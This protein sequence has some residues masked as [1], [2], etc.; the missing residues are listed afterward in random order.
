MNLFTLLLSIILLTGKGEF[1]VSESRKNQ[2]VTAGELREWISFLASDEM[3]GRRNGSVES[4][5]AAAWISGK[6]SEFGVGFVNDKKDFFQ[7]YTF[8]GRGGNV[9]ERNVIGMIKGTNPALKDQILVITAHFDHI[10]IRKGMKPDSV[11]NGADDNASGI[12]ALLGVAKYIGRS[13]VKPGRTVLFAAVSGEESGMRGSRYFVSNCPFQ[14]TNIVADINFEMIGHSELLG[15][16]RYYM[17]G[18][19]N[20]NLDDLIK[21]YKGNEKVSLI[22][23]LPIAEQLFFQSDNIAFS[24]ISSANGLTK[25]IPSGT[26]ATSTMASYL[27]T[28]DDEADLFDFDNMTELVN[29]FGSMV[30]W[31]SNSDSEIKWTDAK[32]AKP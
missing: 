8:T 28:I 31:L 1:Q 20:S 5:K 32:Y 18:C 13:S 19:R 21:G 26:F 4:E 3:Q 25:G 15:K 2:S 16:N 12:C 6:F 7:E 9:A 30:L 23:T 24:R 27:H 11:C 29:Y 17:T 22:D 10:G 14:V